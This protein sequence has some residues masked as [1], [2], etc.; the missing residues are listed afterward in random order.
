MKHVKRQRRGF[1]VHRKRENELLEMIKK[2][3]A[4]PGPFCSATPAGMQVHGADSAESESGCC[5]LSRVYC[6]PEL[7]AAFELDSG[8]GATTYNEVSLS[9]YNGMTITE[10]GDGTFLAVNGSHQ[11]TGNGRGISGVTFETSSGSPPVSEF[12]LLAMPETLITDIGGTQENVTYDYGVSFQWTGSS[13]T[14][15]W[16]PFSG[17]SGQWQINSQYVKDG[18]VC[19]F[20]GGY[21]DGGSNPAWVQEPGGPA[22]PD[23]S[24]QTSDGAGEFSADYGLSFTP[25]AGSNADTLTVG[26]PGSN[27]GNLNLKSGTSGDGV[28]VSPTGATFNSASNLTFNFSN[29][30]AGSAAVQVGGSPVVV[31]GNNLSDVGNAATAFGNIKQGAT[32]SATGVIE[33]ATAAESKAATATDKAATASNLADYVS[34]Q[35][36][37]DAATVALDVSLGVNSKV[38][39]AGNRTLGNPTNLKSGQSG[40]IS[41]T[42][43]ATGT[44]TL[45]YA[46]NWKFSG[47]TAPTLSTAAGSVDLLTWWYDGTT[48]FATLG[49]DFK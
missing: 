36:L 7:N 47:G 20:P 38:T 49:T 2:G 11:W 10:Q 3:R 9:S 13:N 33:L 18:E 15:S 16:D 8:S 12:T 45:A 28:T 40:L 30:G 41:I 4:L 1:K 14:L 46:S 17:S 31:S 48:L 39:L 42:Q 23:G 44:R 22:G 43:D 37:T 29:S 6:S 35:T 5:G 19:E 26:D 34:P 25:G 32:T 27:P 21:E 24:I